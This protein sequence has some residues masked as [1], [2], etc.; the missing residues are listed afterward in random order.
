[1]KRAEKRSCLLFKNSSYLYGFFITQWWKLP[2]KFM[3]HLCS[4]LSITAGHFTLEFPSLY[5]TEDVSYNKYFVGNIEN[6]TKKGPDFRS[7]IL[8]N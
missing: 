6:L 4:F 1:V 7:G 3:S 2:Q 5:E 8:K